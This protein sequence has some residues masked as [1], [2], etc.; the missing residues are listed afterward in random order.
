MNS[1]SGRVCVLLLILAVMALGPT[2]NGRAQGVLRLAQPVTVHAANRAEATEE[3][4]SSPRLGLL[5]VSRISAG[6][7]SRI[8]QYAETESSQLSHLDPATRRRVLSQLVL[9]EM[10]EVV[11]TPGYDTNLL[12]SQERQEA[13]QIVTQV[14]SSGPSPSPT[15]PSPPE[16][17]PMP[18]IP[19]SPT[20]V[21][22]QPAP[23]PLPPNVVYVHVVPPQPQPVY[24]PYTH[25]ILVPV[26]T[27][28]Q[29]K[30]HLFCRSR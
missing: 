24:V 7:L 27:T 18:P 21:P 1:P 26:A 20:P 12:T 4:P 25:S 30:H 14:L 15:P 16:P 23:V 8:R 11:D 17:T 22:P 2:E 6:D 13:E 9:N 3:T 5:S 29:H 19:P 10:A 28:P